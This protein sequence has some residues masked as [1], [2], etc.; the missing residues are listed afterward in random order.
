MMKITRRILFT[1]LFLTVV[2][3]LVGRPTPAKA[4]EDNTDGIIPAGTIIDDDLMI[5]AFKIVID[6]TVNGNVFASGSDVTVNGTINGNLLLNASRATINGEI[7]GSIAAT[8]WEVYLNGPVQGSVY[9]SGASLV[10]NPTAHINRNLIVTGFSI[11][12][13]PGAVIE[14]EMMGNSYQTIVAGTIGQD[15]SLDCG[16]VEISGQIG[17]DFKASNIGDPDAGVPNMEWLNIFASINNVSPPPATL[18]PGLRIAPEAQIAGQLSYSSQADQSETIQST[19]QDG[20]QF[21]QKQPDPGPFQLRGQWMT[22]FIARLRELLTLL[23]LGA[24]ALWRFPQL[25]QRTNQVLRQRFLP[26]TGWGLVTV[27]GGYLLGGVMLM[28]VILLGILIAAITLG[29]LAQAVFGIG[30]ST[31]GLLTAIFTLLVVYGSKVVV[32]YLAG[33]LVLRSNQAE[34]GGQRT[35]RLLIGVL[36]YVLLR[37]IPVVSFFAAVLATLAGLGAIW[38]VF[39][40]WRQDKKQTSNPA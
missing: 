38:L 30:L 22:W 3:M 39:R 37:S 8:G 23:A 31:L 4:F 20:I 35:L 29:G 9:F 1:L 15:V 12:V 27:I 25:F 26:A 2:T 5:S 40:Q 34:Q 7:N 24:L 10:V 33:E 18:P 6:G 11:E 28:L 19:P 13:Q 36:I 14:K 32:A 21:E 16:A 17:G